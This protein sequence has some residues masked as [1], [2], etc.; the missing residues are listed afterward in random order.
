MIPVLPASELVPEVLKETRADFLIAS[1][2]I[3]PLQDVEAA[4]SAIQHTLWV[5]EATSRYV[6]FAH[7]PATGPRSSTWDR[8][9]EQGRESASTEPPA[10]EAGST[11]P[12]VTAV[13]L[14]TGKNYQIVEFTQKVRL[15]SVG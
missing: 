4:G 9:V 8:V 13:W 10:N 14:N 11:A 1:A 7:E 15:P 5:V 3:M 6:E 12:N 2:G